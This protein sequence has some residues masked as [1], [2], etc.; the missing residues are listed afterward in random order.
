MGTKVTVVLI[1]FLVVCIFL[2]MSPS[3]NIFFLSPTAP[4]YPPMR[5]HLRPIAVLP[6]ILYIPRP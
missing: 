1:F 6:S 4:P 2:A 5:Q 3:T